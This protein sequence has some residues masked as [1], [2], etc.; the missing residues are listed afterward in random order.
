MRS[1]YARILLCCSALLAV[2]FSAQKHPSKADD[3]ALQNARSAR[4]K[5]SRELP[6][7]FRSLTQFQMARH[8]R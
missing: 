6:V 8:F 2:A 1:P 4:L 5:S 3:W 7:R